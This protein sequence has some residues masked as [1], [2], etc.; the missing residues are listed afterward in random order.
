MGQD[1]GARGTSG[2]K[3]VIAMLGST[4][5]IALLVLTAFLLVDDNNIRCVEGELQDNRV[6]QDGTFEPRRETFATLEEAEAFVCKRI[7]YP[8]DTGDLVLTEVDVLRSTNLGTLIEGDGN[9]SI[10]FAYARSPDE[11]AVL[12][13]QVS[14]PPQ[15]VP[16]IDA[17]VERIT[18]AG[19]E[20]ILLR[21]ERGAFVYWSNG[22]FDFAGGSQ[23]GESLTLEEMLAIL[24]SVR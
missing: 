17:S 18:V 8:R 19:D 13:L 20:A 22:G 12:G 9:A 6:G 10:S 7:P 16:G 24:E 23:L 2:A 11:P 5:L 15:G 21:P 3:V 14:F 4:L 1:G